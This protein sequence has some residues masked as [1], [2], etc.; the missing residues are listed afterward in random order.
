MDEIEQKKIIL[1]AKIELSD[2]P[3][4]S[5]RTGGGLGTTLLVNVGENRQ[6][7]RELRKKIPSTFEGVRTIVLYS[8]R[9]NEE[10][11]TK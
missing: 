5:I 8:H 10:G 6:L 1:K 2:K 11:E 9:K 7:S 4:Y 3:E